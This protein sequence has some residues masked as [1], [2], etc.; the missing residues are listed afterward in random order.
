MPFHT[1]AIVTDVNKKPVPQYFN[2]TT[3]KY[4]VIESKNGMLGVI[5]YDS[6][7]NEIVSQNLV[8]KITNKLDELIEV[9]K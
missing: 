7:G 5:L 1:K 8:D 9:V 3:D 2:S 6:Q 4:E